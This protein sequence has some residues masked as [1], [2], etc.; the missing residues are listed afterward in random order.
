MRPVVSIA[1]AALTVVGLC[2]IGEAKSLEEI[3]KEKGI[4][5]EEDYKEAVKKNDLAYYRLGRGIT[6]ESR[7]GKTTAHIGGRLQ[8]R[9][10][11]TDVDADGAE[12]TSDFNIQRMR[13]TMRGNLLRKELFY[14]WQHDFGGSG[15]ATLKDAVIGYRF[16]EP[17]SLQVGQ[18]KAPTSRQQLTSSG[19]QMFVDRSLADETFNLGRD[20]GLMVTGSV[21]DSLVEYMAGV[22]NGNGENRSNSNDEHLFAARVDINPLGKFAMDEPSFNEKKPLLNIGASYARQTM[23]QGES[24]NSRLTTRVVN[25]AATTFGDELDWWTAT[26]NVHF[27]YL[28][29]SAAGEYYF[30]NV[31][32]QVGQ[33]YDADGYYLQL[34][35]QIIPETLELALRYSAIESTDTGALKSFEQDEVQVGASY[36][37]KKHNAKVNADYTRH[38]DDLVAGK[39]DNIVRLQ[40]QVIF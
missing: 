26:A 33:E 28:G 6:L 27:K 3:L 30:A 23:Q 29:L 36:Y 34:G 18:F 5:T 13:V 22:F 37:F 8:A 1:L 2:G 4:I 14:A 17:F 19:S 25:L 15:G 38:K 16:A 21:A 20:R 9:Y 12:E 11:Y 40:A 32:P 35:Y 39:D 24:V 7:D 10:T 31:D